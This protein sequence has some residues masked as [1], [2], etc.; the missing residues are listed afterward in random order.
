MKEKHVLHV[1]G[2]K[3]LCGFVGQHR[4]NRNWKDGAL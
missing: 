1:K 3:M 4:E 2:L